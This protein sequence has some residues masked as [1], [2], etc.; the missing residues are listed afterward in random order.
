MVAG[1]PNYVAK[2]AHKVNKSVVF[3]CKK[4]YTRKVKY[5][6]KNDV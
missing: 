2:Y 5:R 4:Q 1:T 6:G 3:K